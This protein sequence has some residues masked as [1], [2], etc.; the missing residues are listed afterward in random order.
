MLTE[1]LMLR[2]QRMRQLMERFNSLMAEGRYRVA[3]E[4]VAVEAQQLDPNNPVPVQ[5][6]LVARTTGYFY[7]QIGVRVARQKGFVDTLWQV[8]LSH[9]PFPDE[10]P[11]VYPDA[12]VWRQLTAKRKEKYESMDLAVRRPMERKI[13][14]QLEVPTQVEVDRDAAPG[15]ARL[16]RRLSQDRDRGRSGGPRRDRLRHRHASHTDP[17][18]HH[19]AFGA[20]ADPPRHGVDLHH[21]RRGAAHHDRGPR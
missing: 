15:S 16:P 1:N 3:E 9:V 21:P 7:D 6:T 10:P 11:I 17:A 13:V 14:Q 12:E 19:P 20:A 8:E 2:E 18:R 4:L 5:A